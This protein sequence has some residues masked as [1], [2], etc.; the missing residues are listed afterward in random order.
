DP[1]GNE[2]FIEFPNPMDSD[3]DGNSVIYAARWSGGF[4][5]AGRNN[6]AIYSVTPKNFTPAPMPNF[7]TA[8]A[9]QLVGILPRHSNT[10]RI[11][12][13]HAILRRAAQ[14]GNGIDA[15]LL[16]LANDKSK[17]LNNRT[18]ALFT[19][20]QLRG[21]AST[22]A[23]AAMVSDPTIAALALRALGDDLAQAK[24]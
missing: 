2:P 10:R 12:A 21:A 17:S 22:Q 20:K 3:V 11:E 15:Q 13:Q 4:S 6:G 18:A 1:R 24:S 19:Y 7:N 5:W 16:A 23:I 14:L 9:T 8:S